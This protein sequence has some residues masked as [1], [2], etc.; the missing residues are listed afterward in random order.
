MDE[1]RAPANITRREA[2]RMGAGVLASAAV[3]GAYASDAD[4]WPNPYRNI[5]ARKGLACL[6]HGHMHRRATLCA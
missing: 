5:R 1:K 2:V 6:T 4:I 3:G